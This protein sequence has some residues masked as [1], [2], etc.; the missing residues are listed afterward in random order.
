MATIIL[1]AKVKLPTESMIEIADRDMGDVPWKEEGSWAW[2]RTGIDAN[3]IAKVF[4]HSPGMCMIKEYSGEVTLIKGDFDDI[5][6]KWSE[7]ISVY[8]PEIEFD[9]AD[10]ELNDDEDAD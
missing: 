5:Y 4:S 7:N 9:P 3:D 10:E 8:P 2:R 1:K 6:K